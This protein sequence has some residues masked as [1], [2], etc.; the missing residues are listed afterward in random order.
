MRVLSNN[1]F[2]LTCERTSHSAEGFTTSK[3]FDSWHPKELFFD[4]QKFSEAGKGSK[5]MVFVE[6]LFYA[7][8]GS[9]NMNY[10]LLPNGKLIANLEQGSGYAQ[11]GHVRY[12]CDKNSN[13]VRQ[14]IASGGSTNTN[15]NNPTGNI[16]K[17]CF[18]GNVTVCT[19]EQ[20]CNRATSRRSGVKQWD[21]IKQFQP[22]VA[23]AKSRGLS[24]GVSDSSTPTTSNSSSKLDRAKSTCTELGFTLGSEKHGECVW[25]MMDN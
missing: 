2:A 7:E 15:S 8:S 20:L 25:K 10:R 13:E 12:K 6:E 24:C 5:A 11:T 21:S 4:E 17:S 1:A 18:D 19:P 9:L 16:E 22:F 23:E 14:L 3:A